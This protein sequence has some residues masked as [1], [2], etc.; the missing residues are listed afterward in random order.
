MLEGASLDSGRVTYSRPDETRDGW[1]FQWRRVPVTGAW[2]LEQLQSGANVLA[3]QEDVFKN[4]GLAASM[5]RVEHGITLIMPDGSTHY[6]YRI[7]LV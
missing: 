4:S 7:R 5:F 1:R 2:L 6:I 3:F